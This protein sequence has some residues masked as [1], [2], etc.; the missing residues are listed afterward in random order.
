LGLPHLGQVGTV[1]LID[2][3]VVTGAMTNT[4]ETKAEIERQAEALAQRLPPYQ[5]KGETPAAYLPKHV[6]P[7][8]KLILN[9]KGIPVVIPSPEER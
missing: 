2:V 8:P 3:D 1:G 6:P 7:A 9:E 5:P 4:P